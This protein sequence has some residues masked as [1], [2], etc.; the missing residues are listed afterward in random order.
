MVPRSNI[1][2]PG[3]YPTALLAALLLLMPV[4]ASAQQGGGIVSFGNASGAPGTTVSLEFEFDN[5]DGADALEARARIQ[6]IE[7]FSEVDLTSLCE[8]ASAVA[9]SCILNDTNRILVTAA[10]P[11]GVPLASFSGSIAFTISPTVTESLVVPLEWNATE[12]QGL[13]FTPSQAID[14]QIAVNADGPQV[15]LLPEALAFD[16]REVGQTSP[17]QDLQV[18]NSGDADGLVIGEV[19]LPSSDFEIFDDGCSGATLAQSQSCSIQV[20]FAPTQDGALGGTLV[21]PSSV[22]TR[23][24]PLT[25]TGTAPRLDATPSPQTLDFGVVP[26]GG[27]ESITGQFSNSGTAPLD[28]S[29]QLQAGADAFEI[30]PDP[31]SFSNI[32]P[33]ASVAFEITFSPSTGASQSASLECQSNAIDTPQFDYLLTAPGLTIFEDRFEP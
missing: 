13:T 6:G 14:G 32:A 12:D 17:P 21:V 27:S 23:S 20:A 7:A 30:Q 3:C 9:V 28:V 26:V 19:S 1:E 25:G 8:N 11:P 4:A 2:S 33:A 16:S 29:C 18:S 31:L 15:S 22:G 5:N 24:A 10:N